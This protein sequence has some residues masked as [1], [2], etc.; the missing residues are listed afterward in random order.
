MVWSS[1]NTNPQSVIT[2]SVYANWNTQAESTM[3]KVLLKRQQRNHYYG[4]TLS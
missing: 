1:A 4:T 2:F 3:M